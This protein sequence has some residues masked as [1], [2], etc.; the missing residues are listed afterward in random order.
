MESKKV[1]ISVENH[2]MTIKLNN[3][4]DKNRCDRFMYAEIANAVNEA[5]D[6]DDVYVVIF[7]GDRDNFSTGGRIDATKGEEENALY[8]ESL[9]KYN[10]AWARLNK[11]LIAAIE[12][13][14][15]AGGFSDSSRADIAIA[16]RGVK[17]ALPEILRG[18]FP[19]MVQIP[20]VDVIPKKKLLPMLFTGEAFEAD[21]AE[22]CGLITKAVDDADFW[23]TVM[24]YAE[25]I[26]K[27]PRDLMEVGRETYYGF[28][29]RPEAERKEYGQGQL[30][31]ILRLQAKYQKE[32]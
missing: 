32:V 31:K 13:D 9:G 27:M 23:P 20:I 26:A 29:S 17:F 2:I 6:N 7:T 1:L 11:P 18:G 14:C 8:I 12:G 25:T 24:H 3:P 10:D 4:E 19:C 15:L 5:V 22:K 16:R 30:A 21:D 28:K